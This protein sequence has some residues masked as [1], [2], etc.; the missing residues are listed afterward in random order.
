MKKVYLLLLMLLLSGGAQ[1]QWISDVIADCT[2]TLDGAV[3]GGA[4]DTVMFV[5]K[6]NNQRGYPVLEIN[7]DAVKASSATDSLTLTY[8]I[9]RA[10]L[11]ADTFATVAFKTVQDYRCGAADVAFTEFDWE[12]DGWYTSILDFDGRPWDFMQL[13]AHFKGESANDSL[14]L[15]LKFR[16]IK[17]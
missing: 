4:L 16:D 2:I 9:A 10:H 15:R 13:V 17:Y 14:E 5:L 1:A 6:P 7:P 11:P 12:D 3:A 8:R